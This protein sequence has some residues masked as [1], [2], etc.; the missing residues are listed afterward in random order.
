MDTPCET[1]ALVI[2]GAG[3]AGICALNA[4]VKYLPSASKVVVIDK[5]LRWGGQWVNQ[6]DFVRLHQPY[7]IFTAGERAW[8]FEGTKPRGHLATKSEILTHFEDIVSKNV[9][10]KNLELVTLFG[11]EYKKH[12][13]V[14]GAV[15]LTAYCLKDCFSETRLPPPAAVRVRADKMIKA[16]G[17]D[18]EIK[19]PLSFTSQR[20]VSVCP[21]DVLKPAWNTYMRSRGRDKPIVLIGSGKTAMD[22][23]YQVLTPTGAG[24]N[25]P[26]A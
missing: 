9:E 15:E 7:S 6:Y 3:Y 2:I 8:S 26:T 11:Y 16:M 24:W 19:R 21:A 1:C 10:E 12:E 4:A 14:D 18:I 23:I 20:V 5:G 22:C 17:F 13:V 25:S